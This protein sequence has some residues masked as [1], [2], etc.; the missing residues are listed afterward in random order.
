VPIPQADV[1]RIHAYCQRKTAEFDPTWSR[2]VAEV[3]DHTVTLIEIERL[4]AVGTE[5]RLRVAQLRYSPP[6]HLWSLL[7]PDGGDA[8]HPVDHEPD[9]TN[10]FW[11]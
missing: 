7:S 8:F 1:V 2:V 4:P 6:D 3:E 9:P 11:G 10:I 5:L